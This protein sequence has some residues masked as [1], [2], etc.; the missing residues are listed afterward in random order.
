VLLAAGRR[1][2]VDGLGLE[3]AR[4]K[5]V[6]AGIL[7]NGRL[8]TSNRRVYAI[9]DVMGAQSPQAAIYHAGLVIQH[10]LFRQR[11]QIVESSVPRVTFTDPELAHVGLTEDDARARGDPFQVLRWPYRENERAHAERQIAGHIKAIVDRAGRILG[12]TIVGAGAGDL[13]ST[14]S[15]ALS[16]NLN[17]RAMAGMVVPYPT[18]GEIGKRA[19]MTYFIPRLTRPWVRRIIALLRRLR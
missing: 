5:H 13:I 1:P 16:Q 17:I 6:P 19:A 11:V 7:V 18:V 14:W 12:A 2:N 4:I 10:A 8:Q 15:L 3:A 9:G